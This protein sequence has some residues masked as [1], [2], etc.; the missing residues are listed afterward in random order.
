ML[1]ARAAL[2]L[3][4]PASCS[5][6][7]RAIDPP[8]GGCALAEAPASRHTVSYRCSWCCSACARSILAQ[9]PSSCALPTPSPPPSATSAASAPDA[10]ATAHSTPAAGP[11]ISTP[12][13]ANGIRVSA[14]P[15]PPC[16]SRAIDCSAPS[17]SAGCT[18]VPASDARRRSRSRA[19]ASPPPSHAASSA[20]NAGPYCSPV[21]EN[22]A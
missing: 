21:A 9:K 11:R 8:L 14:W 7:T 20:R 22:A 12:S 10:D 18:C 1:A 2:P 5:A 6:P 4:H 17:R 19:V 3:C 16:L 15:P 13:T